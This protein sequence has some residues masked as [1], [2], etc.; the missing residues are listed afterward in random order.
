[1][2][3]SIT[4]TT[5]MVALI[6]LGGGL[7]TVPAH[8]FAP[9]DAV[10]AL[11]GSGEAAPELQPIPGPPPPPTPLTAA[12]IE[13]QAREAEEARITRALNAETV[14]QS[15]LADNERAAAEAAVEDQYRAEVA[16]LEA[17]TERQR[18]AQAEVEASYQEVL[19]QHEREMADWRAT[20]EAC[21]RGDLAR[22]RAGKA[23]ALSG[24]RPGPAYS[25][26]MAPPVG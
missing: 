19:A 7:A 25:P 1:M 2:G 10:D 24:S 15:D 22:C 23:P 11:L 14:A 16:A 26:S 13:A 8:A 3:L 17:E 18:A 12:Q 4:R 5:V 20:A 6:S 21:R 9:Q